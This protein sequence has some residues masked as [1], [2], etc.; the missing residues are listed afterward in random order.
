LLPDGRVLTASGDPSPGGPL[1]ASIF[2]PP[3]L[4]SGDNPSVRPT[5]TTAPNKIG[6]GRSFCIQTSQATTITKVALLRA[7]SVTHMINM[8]QR[9]L[10][11]TP[12]VSGNMLTCSF[13]YNG[14]DA[15]PGN[16][17]LFLVNNASPA[18]PSIGRW[19]TVGPLD[20]TPPSTILLVPGGCSM[21]SITL[22]WNAPA[23]ANGCRVTSY[24]IRYS[25]SPITNETDWNN[26]TVYLGAPAPLD[27]GKAQQQN[28]NGLNSCTWYY[29]AIKAS[30]DLGQW[31]EMSNEVIART[32]CTSNGQ[33][34]TDVESSSIDKK[35]VEAAL[36][37]EPP[38]PNPTADEVQVKYGIPKSMA[39][40]TLTLTAY[41]AAGR[42]VARLERSAA[43]PGS[44]QA[45][46]DLKGENGARVRAGLYWLRLEVGGQRVT[47]TLVV[48]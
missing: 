5:I 36:R 14:S 46:W 26:A 21:S 7:G 1:V 18:V 3:Y 25:T 6:Y 16:Y 39:G 47:R 31:S 22:K 17:L 27:P 24:Q 35:V 9:Y 40:Q 34:L 45:L 44:F 11:F 28:V 20:A 15:P 30:D 8:D 29:F 37:L 2:S 38:M 43:K 4:F 10:E 48:R 41:D 42:R 12:T 13:P 32:K 19:V 23:N 33:C